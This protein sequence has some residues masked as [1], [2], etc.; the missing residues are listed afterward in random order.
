MSTVRVAIPNPRTLEELLSFLARLGFIQSLVSSEQGLVLE[1]SRPRVRALL[2]AELGASLDTLPL[3]T[4]VSNKLV[5]KA[6]ETLGV[7]RKGE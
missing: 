2:E 3:E 7:K 1:S 6:L 4:P 5:S